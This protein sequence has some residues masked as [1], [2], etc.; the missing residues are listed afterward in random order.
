MVK[1]CLH[2]VEKMWKRNGM[3]KRGEGSY[4]L[5]KNKRKSL[6]KGEMK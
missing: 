6:P 2:Y 5:V 1:F 3:G 4:E